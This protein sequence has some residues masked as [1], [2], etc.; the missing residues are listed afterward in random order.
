M[1]PEPEMRAQAASTH[2][3]AQRTTE[4]RRCRVGISAAAGRARQRR[5]DRSVV[6]SSSK[7]VSASLESH[8]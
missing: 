1:P 5:Q 7:M 2:S 4:S 3:V 8:H 6:I